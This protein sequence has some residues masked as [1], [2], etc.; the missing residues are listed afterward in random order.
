M[1][2]KEGFTLIIDMF[3]EKNIDKKCFYK[4]KIQYNKNQN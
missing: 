4:F 1:P 2:F 3:K